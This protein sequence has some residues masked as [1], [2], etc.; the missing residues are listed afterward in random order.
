MKQSLPGWVGVFCLALF[1]V[2][3]TETETL[4]EPEKYT[5]VRGD[6]L[7]RIARQHGVG[8][9]RLRQTNRISGDLI[10]VGQVLIIPGD[11]DAR[12]V[13]GRAKSRSSRRSSKGS[14]STGASASLR[15]PAAKPCLSGP[16][17][18]GG[19]GDEPEMVR[20]AGLS[21]VQVSAAM[22]PI[23]EKTKN[24][25]SGDWPTGVI[26]FHIEVACTGRVARVT[27]TDNGGMDPGLVAC[28]QDTLRYTSFPA[29]DMP[30][31]FSFGYPMRFDVADGF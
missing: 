9:E 22:R 7:T 2:S 20:S 29:H 1:L 14:A 30:D 23:L 31:G 18:S 13:D 10:E 24:C 27:A 11:G 21:S 26:T 28:V 17:L 15:M 16:A 8:L 3:C 25:V 12:V 5:V 6:T 4:P 19:S